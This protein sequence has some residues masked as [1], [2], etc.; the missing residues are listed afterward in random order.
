VQQAVM[1]FMHLGDGGVI[2]MTLELIL[3]AG[4]SKHASR[5]AVLNKYRISPT[6]F[7]KLSRVFVFYKSIQI[8]D[9]PRKM[10][11]VTILDFRTIIFL[12]PAQLF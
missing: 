2:K 3:Y 11:L 1:E 4:P 9:F 10:R 8:D 12:A 5:L 7:A 6:D